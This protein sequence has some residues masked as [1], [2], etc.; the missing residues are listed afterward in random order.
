M[1]EPFPYVARVV[2]DYLVEHLDDDVRVATKVPNPLPAKLVTIRTVPLR[3]PSDQQRKK[4]NLLST[5]RVTIY[6]WN[7]DEQ[8]AAELAET[9]RQVLVDARMNGAA[10]IRDVEIVGEPTQSD[11][12]DTGT[13][14]FP[15]TADV[16][17]RALTATTT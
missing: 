4:P 2:R 12:P 7:S 15:I 9:V 13:P 8:V 3:G 5:R 10:W 17:L 1:S 16:L 6:C 11:D 14:R